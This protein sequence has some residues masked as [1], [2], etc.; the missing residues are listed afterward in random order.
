MPVVRPFLFILLGTVSLATAE[1]RGIVTTDH[2]E[3]LGNTVPANDTEAMLEAMY[4]QWSA[5]LGPGAG[6]PGKLKIAFYTDPSEYAKEASLEFRF[7][8]NKDTLHVLSTQDYASSVAAGLALLYVST[9]YPNIAAR[10]DAPWL[11]SGLRVYFAG[12]TWSRGSPQ[13]D[14]LKLPA[15]LMNALAIQAILKK[16]DWWAMDKAI[17]GTPLEIET[18]RLMY[19][20]GG[21]A[22]W[23]AIF[24]APGEG[25]T[26]RCASAVPEFMAA[27]DAGKKT[28]EAF[29]AFQKAANVAGPQGV[30]KLAREYFGKQKLEVP[31]K[32]T[33]DDLAAETAHYSIWLEKSTDRKATGA[34]SGGI[35]KK[36]VDEGR[37]L[38]DLKWKMEL[39]YEKYHLAFRLQR[40]PHRKSRIRIYA[41]ESRYLA[42]GG[43]RGSAA[44]F[45]PTTKELVGFLS[46]A[47]FDPLFNVL[48]HEGCHQFFD[49][50]FPQYGESDIP[51]WFSEGFAECLGANEVRGKDLHVFTVKG[52]GGFHLR[53][54]KARN[55]TLIGLE[56][57]L[58]FDRDGFMGGG[59][60][61]YAR[62]WS[63]THF[64]WNYPTVDAGHGE[65]SEVLIRM[66][67]GFKA[68][69]PRD[70]VWREAFTKFGKP[71]DV[72]KVEKEWHGYT[73]A[74]PTRD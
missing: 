20:L 68:G 60:D 34:E 45:N 19:D 14:S 65:Y 35:A 26:G 51:M 8:V 73:K 40:Q 47:D 9:A 53:N 49:L 32:D 30:D 6:V 66:I 29:K 3:I 21:W 39:M 63:F 48:S 74:L 18:R 25:G 37:F 5:K 70:A 62:A 24:N 44:Y 12:A 64:L 13:I 22:A 55:A 17:A 46:S 71:L 33:G 15:A 27:L 10:K 56:D 69:K 36:R 43:P 11:L 42:S 58:K 2:F 31:D 57:L 52:R 28:D 41:S 67:D 50:A 61:N 54:F 1:A 38:S 4:G 16:G 72:T 23:W 7:A 59:Y